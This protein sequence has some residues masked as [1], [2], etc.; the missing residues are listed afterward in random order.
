MGKNVADIKL[1]ANSGIELPL[2]NPKDVKKVLILGNTIGFFGYPG[3]KCNISN[4]H[5]EDAKRFAWMYNCAL[6]GVEFE[7]LGEEE[8]FNYYSDLFQK[9]KERYGYEVKALFTEM[10]CN[11]DYGYKL[12]KYIKEMEGTGKK[13][14]DFAIMNPP[15]DRNLHLKF[16]EKVIKV[17]DK[18]VNISPVRWLQDPFAPYNKNSDYYKFEDSILKRIESLVIYSAKNAT[19]FFGALFATNVGIYVCSDKGGFN[20]KHVDPIID[21]IVKKTRESNW[22][23][24]NQK[25]F[26]KRGCKQEKP[27]ALNV[28]CMRTKESD[29]KIYIMC[30]SYENQLKTQ[31][32]K[33]SSAGANGTHFEFN[34]EAER[35][36]FYNCYVSDFMMWTYTW[37]K[38]DQHITSVKIPYFGD[39][40]EPWTNAR[41]C[42]YFGI[43][44]FIS[45]TEAEPGSEWETIL[46]TMKKYA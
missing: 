35:R 46:E 18:T 42:E 15:Y 39:Y 1:T 3:E 32:M 34:T 25:D 17:A 36:N 12:N 44:G 27:Y 23:P 11:D 4:I 10:R 40:T 6:L 20:Y 22:L 16:L 8:E 37:W 21:K 2:P 7:I 5:G 28:A 29:D 9:I 14:F 31:L 43:T 33:E 26:Y 13:R 41:F 45:D 38:Y 24:F 30:R 19:K